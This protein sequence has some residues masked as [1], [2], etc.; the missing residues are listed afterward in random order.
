M[1]YEPIYTRNRRLS[2][3][4]GDLVLDSRIK[5][6]KS[7]YVGIATHSVT[8]TESQH[9]WRS[10]ITVDFFAETFVVVKFVVP[11]NYRL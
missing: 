10:R 11:V 4:F 8:E 2:N 1:R 6:N 9:I 7:K 3:T 5:D